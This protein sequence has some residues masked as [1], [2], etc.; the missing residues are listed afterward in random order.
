[1][2]FVIRI[3]SHSVFCVCF[4]TVRILPAGQI[5]GLDP[6]AQPKAWLD[7]VASANT[8]EDEKM[9]AL[10]E[11]LILAKDKRRAQILLEEG[12]LDS[13][14]WTLD[15]YIE[16]VN[17]D[18]K[19]KW[20]NPTITPNER[21]SAKLAAS[22]CVTLGKTHCAAIH[23]EGDMQLIS[24]YEGGPVPE[25]RQVAHML[26]DVPHHVRITKLEDPTIVIPKK[27]IFG[28]RQLSIQQAEDFAQSIKAVIDG[29]L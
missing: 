28:L 6:S 11:I 10:E 2:S 22:C 18:H 23:M 8:S 27:E 12:I 13:L 14:V 15:R 3:V 19:S 5:H 26:H 21:R 9:E 7:V 16:K 25:E 24:L 29:K 20:A 17:H 4:I 1:M